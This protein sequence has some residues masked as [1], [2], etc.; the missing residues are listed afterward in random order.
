MATLKILLSHCHRA[1]IDGSEERNG[2][3]VGRCHDCGTAVTR[4]NLETWKQEWLDGRS[5][6]TTEALREV[7]EHEWTVL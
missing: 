4:Y 7:A 5:P 6:Q 2:V 3:I 1:R